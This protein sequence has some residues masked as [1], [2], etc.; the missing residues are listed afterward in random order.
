VRG[1]P[2]WW[3]SPLPPTRSGIADYASEVL[4]HLAAAP[5][6]LVAP[7]GWNPPSDAG[8]WAGGPIAT[9][10]SGPPPEARELLHLG[11]NP[12]HL[13]IAGRLRRFGG[14]A[15]VHDLVLHHLLVE[16][17]AA[18]DAWE[19]FAAELTAACG[20]S[21][22]A[23]A[24]ARRWGYASRLEPFLYPATQAYLRFADGAV[25]HNA[26]AMRFLSEVLPELPVVQV[27]LAVAALPSADRAEWR[28]RLR[29]APRELLLAHLGFL[30]P[31]KGLG[32]IVRALAALGEL[33]V[34]SRLLVVGEG[35]EGGELEENVRRAGLAERVTLWGFA[36]REDLGGLVAATDIGLV[37]RYPT[38][39]E[40][41]AAALRFLAAGVPV[42]VAGYRQFLEL[43]PQA[44]LR[45]APGR[46]G[47]TD[48]VRWA[49][50]LSSNP[51][52]LAEAGRAARH[53]WEQGRHAPEQAAS[54][55][56]RA[57]E[58]L[59]ERVA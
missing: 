36:S 5:V 9:A 33:G 48:L 14:I 53:A 6:T 4:P 2:L 12:Y 55:L 31:A 52:R 44:A 30:T 56:H 27:P 42:V 21:G 7:P 39:G 40:T 1:G 10:E 47:V 24:R 25:V 28:L 38:A 3:S 13:W 45:I 50:A 58:M 20:T 54:A 22:G 41:S 59:A 35:L 15:V 29:V 51:E 57:V 49:A 37:P 11:N 32:S 18:D 23:L 43:P 26:A 17:A 19:R 8:A 16:E 46:G 34:A